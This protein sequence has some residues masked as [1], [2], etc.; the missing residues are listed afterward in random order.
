M[1]MALHALIH[2]QT[3]L[4]GNYM[5]ALLLQNALRA[6][7]RQVFGSAASTQRSLLCNARWGSAAVSNPNTTLLLC[8]WGRITQ[9]LRIRLAE[10]AGCPVCCLRK[11]RRDSIKRIEQSPVLAAT[12]T[13]CVC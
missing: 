5:P 11:E 7:T 12:N 2:A 6:R 8:T 13:S 4:L 1:H 3:R 9:L 10:I